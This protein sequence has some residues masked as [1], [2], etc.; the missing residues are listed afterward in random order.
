MFTFMN[1]YCTLKGR[2][3]KVSRYKLRPI[4]LAVLILTSLL[5]AQTN[6]AI[7]PLDAKGVSD[8]EASVITDRLGLE[9]SKTGLFTVLGQGEMKEILAI[10]NFPLTGRESEEDVAE[11]GQLLGVEQMMVGSVIKIGNT[12][13]VVLKLHNAQSGAI[14]QATSYDHQ[15]TIAQLWDPGMSVLA[16]I[17]AGK[18]VEPTREFVPA[19]D[20]YLAPARIAEP[21]V[22][23]AGEFVPAAGL[24]VAP[25][26]RRGNLYFLSRAGLGHSGWGDTGRVLT[27]EVGGRIVSLS[28]GGQ[29]GYGSA[30]GNKLWIDFL[31][32][33]DYSFNVALLYEMSLWRL[34]TQFGW[35]FVSDEKIG[36][37]GYRLRVGLD[38]TSG[39]FILI[40]PSADLNL[41]FLEGQSSYAIG[42]DF[43]LKLFN[44]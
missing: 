26:A 12:F 24:Y 15:G 25:A 5:G 19:A 11:A 32:I 1:L 18:L 23:P 22:E 6:L 30:S 7:I 2:G 3:R 43:G 37:F 20:L 41:G 44:P 29:I 21:L 27:A 33:Y 13:T 14:V 39:K 8:I 40:R 4:V 28:W 42:L 10:Q 17:I 9:L 38:I 36:G 16:R 31:S 34:F 35:G